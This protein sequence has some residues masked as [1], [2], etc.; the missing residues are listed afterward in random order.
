MP[1][2]CQND[3]KNLK[4]ESDLVL[5]SLKSNNAAIV[6]VNRKLNELENC[7]PNSKRITS[8]SKEI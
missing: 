6:E 5:E 1:D 4:Q 2:K 7:F 3:E 8:D